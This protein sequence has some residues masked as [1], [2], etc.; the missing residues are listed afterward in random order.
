MPVVCCWFAL[1]SSH[2]G[3]VSDKVSIS[4]ENL[5]RGITVFSWEVV[6]PG[7]SLRVATLKDITSME[8]KHKLGTETYTFIPQCP[9]PGLKPEEKALEWYRKKKNKDSLRNMGWGIGSW[10]TIN[11]KAGAAVFFSPL[12]KPT[13]VFSLFLPLTYEGSVNGNTSGEQS[14]GG[15]E[16]NKEKKE[17]TVQGKA[18]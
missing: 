9:T 12:L 6:A 18:S 17:K 8:E 13:L 3:K 4:S 2:P 1:P 10:E 7:A 11:C 5:H 16:E 15:Q 14:K